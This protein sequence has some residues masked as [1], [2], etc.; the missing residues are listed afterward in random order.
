MR[1]R[2]LPFIIFLLV[3]A[4]TL[5]GI[6]GIGELLLFVGTTAAVPLALGL[7]VVVGL[8]AA[9][10]SFRAAKL[11]PVQ[12]PGPAQPE[13]VRTLDFGAGY[14]IGQFV[15]FFGLLLLLVFIFLALR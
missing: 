14:L 8:V 15:L 11:P 7:V 1:R 3:L 5:T 2:L 6:V 10:L 4:T 13:P 12:L 9:A